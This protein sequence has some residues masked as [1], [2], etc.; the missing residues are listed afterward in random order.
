MKKS[1]VDLGMHRDITRRDFINGVA[2]SIGASI[3]PSG[4]WAS[5]MGAQ[6]LSGYY[7]PALTGMRGSH[8]GSFETAHRAMS[9]EAWEG[10][11]TGE[12]YDLVVVV[13]PGRGRCRDQRSLG[14]LLLQESR[15]RE[16]QD[17]DPRQPR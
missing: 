6:D 5:D 14:G 11:D 13:R 2:A 10:K 17:P 16:G 1:D 7:P 8:P 9:G 15:R 4:A 12:H 3:L